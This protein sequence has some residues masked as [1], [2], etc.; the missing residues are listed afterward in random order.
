MNK[1]DII[2]NQNKKAVSAPLR[3]F[4]K[5]FSVQLEFR[6]RLFNVLAMAG[7]LGAFIIGCVTLITRHDIITALIDWASAIVAFGLT[8]Y[9]MRSQKYLRCYYITI[10]GI[11]LGLFPY[12]YFA[13]MFFTNSSIFSPS[14][15]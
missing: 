13:L 6:V 12:L 14:S 9:A 5:F 10:F 15:L 11:F 8:Y 7:T 4:N 2:P 1:P 3:F